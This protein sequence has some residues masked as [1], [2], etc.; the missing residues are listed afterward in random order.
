MQGTVAL[1]LGLG[2]DS[3]TSPWNGIQTALGDWFTSD[4]AD[5]V[6]VL[7]DA[8]QSFLDFVYSVLIGGEEAQG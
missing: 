7:L 8:L 3:E 1:E 4:F 6:G 2:V 5:S